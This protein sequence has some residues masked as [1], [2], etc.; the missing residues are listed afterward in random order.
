MDCS[1]DADHNRCVIPFIAP[2][3]IACRAALAGARAAVQ[4]IDMNRH[5][6]VHPCF[7]AVDVIPFVPV[8][9]SD[10]PAAVDASRLAGESIAR[11]LELPVYLYEESAARPEL[12]NLAVVRR[13]HSADPAGSGTVPD[14]GPLWFHPTA[15]AV[16]VGARGPLVAY[17][18]DLA[19]ADVSFS[20][21]I[22]QR[23]RAL[24]GTAQ[25][26]VGVKALGLILARRGVAQVSV[27]VTQP[28]VCPPRSVWEFI[29]G[30]ADS[31][32]VEVLGSELVGIVSTRHLPPEDIAAMQFYRPIRPGQIIE[33]WLNGG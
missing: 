26:L 32:G 21:Q 5:S 24:R 10:M 25:E 3:S 31:L 12:R 29:T 28:D 14:F 30:Q 1:M 8:C 19:T 20:R 7:G 6:G 2:V 23:L 33:T 16:A 15:G 17:N 11:Q 9:Q 18:V 27:N 22:A 13:I 4:L